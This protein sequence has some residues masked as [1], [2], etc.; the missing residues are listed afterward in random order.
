LLN[1]SESDSGFSSEDTPTSEPRDPIQPP[2]RLFVFSSAD[3]SGLSRLTDVYA[4]TL[5]RMLEAEKSFVAASVVSLISTVSLAY[6]LGSRRSTFD[7][8]T[9]VVSRSITNLHDQ[10]Q[11]RLP[12]VRRTA[13]NSN[14]FFIFTGQGAQWATM[15]QELVDHHAY[16][17]S[18]EVS[19][20]ILELL[21]CEW[22]LQRELFASKMESRIDSPDFSQPLCT[23]LQIALVELLRTWGVHPKSVVGHSSGEIGKFTF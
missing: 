19:Q 2:N 10:L 23:A 5:H 16:R 9:F 7:H 11:G 12:A 14:V 17:R 18:L 22:S 6:T 20:A 3:K 4:L 15:G 8:R 21:G 1:D 13:K